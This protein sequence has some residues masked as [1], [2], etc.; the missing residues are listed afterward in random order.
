MTERDPGE[1]RRERDKKLRRFFEVPPTGGK[2]TEPPID[3]R[4]E[5][6]KG[7]RRARQEVRAAAARIKGSVRVK[8][9]EMPPTVSD[10]I[11]KSRESRLRAER[12]GGPKNAVQK[13][14]DEGARG[15]MVRS[16]VEIVPGVGDVI[17]GYGA[18]M[19]TDIL[20]GR[21]LDAVD[22]VIY[23][24]ATAIPLV[25]GTLIA[26]PVRAIRV[27]VEDWYE[28]KQT[29]ERNETGKQANIAGG[30]VT[31]LIKIIRNR[32]T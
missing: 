8:P 23:A 13:F 29:G 18:A 28:D 19:G 21:K 22:R 10:V 12:E 4:A 14:F 32:K 30:A 6:E 25:P 7:M 9:M 11:R 17:N 5:M 24:V 15:W 2:P 20:T 31:Q 1:E 26:D 3:V 27:A 16:G